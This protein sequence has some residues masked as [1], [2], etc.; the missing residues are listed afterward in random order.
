MASRGF[1]LGRLTGRVA[2]YAIL[3]VFLVIFLLP[4]IWIWSSALKTSQE[5]GRNPFA[6]PTQLRW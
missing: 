4:F 1:S 6:L 5:I 3:I 2:T